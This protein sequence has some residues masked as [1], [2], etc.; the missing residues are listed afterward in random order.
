MTSDKPAVV[1][2]SG[3]LDS[4]TSLAIAVSEGYQCY[5][6]TFRYGQR[7]Q[8]EIEAAKRI[9]TA[10]GVAQHVIV[11]IDLRVFGGSALTSDLEIPKDRPL[12]AMSHGIPVTYVPARNTIF[13]SFALA[14]AEVLESSDIFIGVNALD[15]SG[16][17]DCRPE[18]IESYQRM[19]NLAT[20]AGV[21][22]RQI[23]TIHTPL[24]QL[25]KAQIIR[26]GLDLGVD[27]S[28]TST[29]YDPSPQGEACG[30]CDACLLRLKGFAENGVKDPIRYRK[31]AG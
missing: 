24:I 4:T 22:G 20:K 17:P 21:E 19:A 30:G 5:A 12:A 3:G 13:L 25:T 8:F 9:A 23:L 6:M 1:L 28:L 29:C 31:S 7:H 18:Y 16:Y 2:L 26:R 27:Y 10:T 14:W 15:Y 11:D